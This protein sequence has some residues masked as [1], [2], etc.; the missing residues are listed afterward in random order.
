MFLEF[1]FALLVFGFEANPVQIILALSMV[2]FAYMMPIP[3]ALGILEASEASMFTLL[4]INP[5][6]GVA[7]SLLIRARDT[8]M[9][10]L[11]L[12]SLSHY[13]L[14]IA[15]VASENG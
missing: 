9:M 12:G 7:V 2:G 14:R 10:G 3:A 15:K 6:I 1:K 5:G 4:G 13:G 8:I 11:G